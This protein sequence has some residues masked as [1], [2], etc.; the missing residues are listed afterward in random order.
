MKREL[1]ANI[2]NDIKTKKL[3]YNIPSRLITLENS[4]DRSSDNISNLRK[5]DYS[6]LLRK[7]NSLNQ[8]KKNYKKVKKN[9]PIVSIDLWNKVNKSNIKT[10]KNNLNNPNLLLKSRML[11]RNINSENSKRQSKLKL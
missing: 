6:P 7:T 8:I 3:F 1:S 11:N 4:S 10:Q 2:R 5:I 9:I